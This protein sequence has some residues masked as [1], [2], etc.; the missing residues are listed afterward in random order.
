MTQIENSDTCYQT[1]LAS[2]NSA[3]QHLQSILDCTRAIL[4]LGT[5]HSGS[6]FA[7]WAEMFAKSLGLIKQTNPQILEVLRSDS[8]VL[9][10]IKEGF[11]TMIRDRGLNRERSIGITCCYEELP[12][13]GIGEVSPW[14]SILALICLKTLLFALQSKICYLTYPISGRCSSMPMVIFLSDADRTDY[15]LCQ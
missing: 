11:H 1:L 13:P 9:A 5:P 4:F 6:G 2:K 15:R 14:S 10:R 3:D 12:L 7:M 8:E